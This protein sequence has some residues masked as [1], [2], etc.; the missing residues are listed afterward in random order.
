MKPIVLWRKNTFPESNI[1]VEMIKLT[2]EERIT[3]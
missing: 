2:K 1:W 3:K